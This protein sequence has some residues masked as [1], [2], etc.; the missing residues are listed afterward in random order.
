VTEALELA[1]EPTAVALGVLGVAPVEE[2][3]AELVVG[4]AAVEDVVG[5]GEDLVG[6]WRSWPWRGRDG[7]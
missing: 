4:D 2:V 1:G 5:G 6:R 7:S 3:L